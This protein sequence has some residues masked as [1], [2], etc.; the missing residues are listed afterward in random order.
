[1]PTKTLALALLLAAAGL[2]QGHAMEA[3]ADFRWK[4]RILL[5]Y[6]T[7]DDPRLQRQIAE[8]T[9][10]PD[11]MAER[12]LL[13]LK[14][15]GAEVEA[16]SGGTSSGAVIRQAGTAD[17]LRQEGGVD[18]RSFQVLLVGKDGGIKLR[19]SDVVDPEEIIALIDSMPMRQTEQRKR[20]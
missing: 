14:V 5:V 3:L 9:Q 2:Q 16:V 18:D 15:A 10:R 4:Q 12:D 8:F 20:N 13:V 6:G 1:M 17:H 11:A 7:E 19:R